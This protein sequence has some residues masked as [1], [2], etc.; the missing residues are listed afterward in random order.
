VSEPAEI[1]GFGAVTASHIRFQVSSNHGDTVQSG[2]AEVLFNQVPEP[3]TALLLT[4]G[5]A[6]LAVGGRRRPQ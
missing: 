2:F 3:S 1:F 4:C 5:L 6:A